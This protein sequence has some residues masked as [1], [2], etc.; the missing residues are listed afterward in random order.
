MLK[1]RMEEGWG[2][3]GN[4]EGGKRKVGLETIPAAASSGRNMNWIPR[5]RTLSGTGIIIIHCQSLPRFRLA[6]SFTHPTNQPRAARGFR[7]LGQC[8]TCPKPNPTP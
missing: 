8:C 2:E 6:A 5:T 3:L 7:I 1:V 4:A